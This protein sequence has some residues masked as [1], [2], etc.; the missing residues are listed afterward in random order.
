MHT[1]LCRVAHLE[2][3]HRTG[4]AIVDGQR[5]YLLARRRNRLLANRQFMPHHRGIRRPHAGHNEGC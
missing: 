5:S 2:T 4:D 1:D 3:Q